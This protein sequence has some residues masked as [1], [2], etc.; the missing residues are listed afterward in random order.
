[1]LLIEPIDHVVP[2]GLEFLLAALSF[3]ILN[4]WPPSLALVIETLDVSLSWLLAWVWSAPS[5]FENVMLLPFQIVDEVV[6]PGTC[7]S[8]VEHEINVKIIIS[9]YEC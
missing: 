1:M 4:I 3:I 6:S 8:S 9:K 5:A 7:S 2:A